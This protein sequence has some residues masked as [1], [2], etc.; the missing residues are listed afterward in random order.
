MFDLIVF[1]NAFLAALR[2]QWSRRPDFR[3]NRFRWPAAIRRIVANSAA[4]FGGRRPR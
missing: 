2:N 3:L 4:V 1:S